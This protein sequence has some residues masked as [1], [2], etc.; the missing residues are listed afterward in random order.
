MDLG[1]EAIGKAFFYVVKGNE[2][3]AFFLY[4]QRRSYLTFL[5]V[6]L[7]VSVRSEAVPI[8]PSESKPGRI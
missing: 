7:L 4:N 5:V 1:A 6:C 3:R 8:M 2:G